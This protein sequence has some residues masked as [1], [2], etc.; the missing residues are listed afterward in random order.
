MTSALNQR[1]LLVRRPQGAPVS[2][3]FRIDTVP[4]ADPGPGDALG[5]GAGGQADR[6]G[7]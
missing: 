2:D 1:V 7:A 4:A 3:D 6:A 5:V